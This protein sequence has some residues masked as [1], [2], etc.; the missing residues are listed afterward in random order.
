MLPQ[1]APPAPPIL[2]HVHDWHTALVPLYLRPEVYHYPGSYWEH[3][4]TLDALH[5]P[6]IVYFLNL[7]IAVGITTQDTDV[8][9]REINLVKKRHRW[10]SGF[11]FVAS[12]F[13]LRQHRLKTC[14]TKLM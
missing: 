3:P 11:R 9:K 5:E 13:S 1:V 12:D 2:L 10:V 7:T 4:D 14:A 6:K 8:N